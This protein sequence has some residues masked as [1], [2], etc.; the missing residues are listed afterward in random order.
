MTGC[1]ISFVNSGPRFSR[2][3]VDFKYTV[4]FQSSVYNI[5]GQH[6]RLWMY[7]GVGSKS[8]MAL[9]KS[10]LP[11][12]LVTDYAAGG[13]AQNLLGRS[14]PVVEWDLADPSTRR[15]KILE[16]VAFLNDNIIPYFDMFLRPGDLVD[17]LIAEGVPAMD[18]PSSLEF[19]LCYRGKD[20][21][22]LVLVGFQERR[23]DLLPEIERIENE[24]LKS[25]HIGPSGYAE[26]VVYYRRSYNL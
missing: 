4:D 15:E 8:L 9:R 7:A 14:R 21:A 6:V 2:R 18:F 11:E 10:H 26:Q 24:G 13:M 19:A 17:R 25:P 5:A 3:D 1:C 16:V 12:K 20:A 23:S 22:R